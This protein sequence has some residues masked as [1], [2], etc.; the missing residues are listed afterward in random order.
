MIALMSSPLAPVIA[1]A[2]ACMAAWKA[3]ELLEANNFL[4]AVAVGA[5]FALVGPY[6]VGDLILTA[7]AD[8][9]PAADA[10]DELAVCMPR[11]GM[12]LSRVG[13][14]LIGVLAWCG[15]ERAR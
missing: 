9:T 15:I 10:E 2:L 4:A 1:F 14:A 6:L 11:I 5:A 12:G 3:S 8:I 7:I 13:F